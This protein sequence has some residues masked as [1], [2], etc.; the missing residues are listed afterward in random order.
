MGYLAGPV[1]VDSSWARSIGY[2]EERDQTRGIRAWLGLNNINGIV[3]T[4]KDGAR[5]FYPGT[6][7]AEYRALVNAKSKG[8]WIHRNLY[9]RKYDLV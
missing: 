7:K 9:D 3:V 5:C 8:K 1:P 2:W 4:F 6:T